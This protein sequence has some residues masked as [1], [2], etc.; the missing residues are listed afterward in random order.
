MRPTASRLRWIFL[1]C[2][3]QGGWASYC[4]AADWPQWLGANR[5]GIWRETGILEKFPP[6]GPKVLWRVPIHEG[7]SGPSVADGRVYVMDRQRARDETGKPMR[8][9]RQGIPGNERILCLDS[10]DGQVIWKN[11]YDCSYKVSYPSGPRTTPLVHQGRVY[12]LGAMG[13]L[14]CLDAKSGTPRWSKNLC[15]EYKVDPPVWGYAAHPLIDGDLLFCLVGGE[16]KA[17]V[18]FRK[19]PAKRYGKL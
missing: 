16:G 14:R 12:T 6:G 5:D 2:L 8:P 1:V 15:Q 3:F 9:T 13:D 19:I 4:Q 10:R 11:E 18:V 7:Y 17:V